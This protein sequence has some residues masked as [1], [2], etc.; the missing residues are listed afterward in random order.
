MEKFPRIKLCGGKNHLKT[1]I[2]IGQHKTGTTSIQRFLQDNRKAL[3]QHGF[4][5]PGKIAGYSHPS[6]FILNVY[7]LAEERFFSM[8]EKIISNKGMEYLS[9]LEIDLK[10]DI[11]HIYNEALQ[12]KY[13]KI[14]WSNE[15]LYL[16]NTKI[17]YKRLF[18]LFSEYSTEIEAVCCFRDVKSYR[19]SY[20]K[21]LA[22]QNISFSDNPDSYR[23]VEI[24]S[25]LFKYK[26]KKDLLSQVFDKC[27]HFSYDPKDNVS[28]FL[29][30]IH[31]NGISTS[32]YRLN[33]TEET[34]KNLLQ[35]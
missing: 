21:Q 24:D 16:L 34:H 23:Y 15:G 20:K 30:A 13:N 4:Y 25:W 8:K 9:N 33:I 18:D 22:K 32:N 12:Q 10:K 27:T 17:E 35:R 14:I 11:G 31:I 7:A 3:V 26:R 5:V 29:E 6:H 19:E 1:I 28:K 2:H